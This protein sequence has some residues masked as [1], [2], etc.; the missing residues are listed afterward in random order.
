MQFECIKS[1]VFDFPFTGYHLIAYVRAWQ[2]AVN[3][4][5][6]QNGCTYAFRMNTYIISVLVVF[7]LQVKHNFPKLSD[8]PQSQAKFIDFV[9]KVDEDDRKKLKKAA[10]Q[11]FEFYGRVYE[12]CKLISLDMGRWQNRRLDKKQ[13]ELTPERQK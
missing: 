7:F 6:A 11:F 8:V 4:T 9:P 13:S 12:K 10:K 3:E 1:S 2:I 5:A